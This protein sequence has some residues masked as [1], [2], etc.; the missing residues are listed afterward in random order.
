M[1]RPPSEQLDLFTDRLTSFPVD[2]EK[3]ELVE[4]AHPPA[5]GNGKINFDAA[6]LERQLRELCDGNKIKV[7]I[8]KH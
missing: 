6:D 4:V 8:N 5:S 3:P 1:K 7:K 2:D